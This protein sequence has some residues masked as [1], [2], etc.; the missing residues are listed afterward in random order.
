MTGT[1][2]GEAVAQ[3]PT[4]DQLRAILDAHE[5]WA[6]SNGRDGRPADFHS[7]DLTR[8][9]LRGALLRKADLTGLCAPKADLTGAR[10]YRADLRGANLADARLRG[11]DLS[12]ADL[13]EA[14]LSGA[15]LAGADLSR[16]DL[17]GANV[18]RAVLRDA[19]LADAD[20]SEVHGLLPGQL[21]GAHLAGAK[22]PADILKFE[23]LANVAEASKATQNLFTT[24]ILVCA[25]T[26]LTIASTTD[27]QLLNNAAPPSSR[28]PILG[29]DIPLVRFYM[30]APLLL[31]CLYVYF[32]LGLQRLWEELS[33]LPAVFPDGRALDKKA[34]PW[35]LNVLVRAH[36][37]RLREARSHLAKWQARISTLLAWGLVPATLVLA[38]AR[39]LRAHD[40]LVTGL[41]IALLAAA[42][43][44]GLAF[45]RLAASTLRGSERRSFMWKRAWKDARALGAGV[46]LGT[47]LV[48]VGLS[49]GVIEGVY[50]KSVATPEQARSLIAQHY[51]IDPRRWL[52]QALDSLGLGTSADLTDA[53]LSTKPANWAPNHPE[54]LDA[55]K[56]A[57]LEHRN[58]RHAMAFN[59]FGVNSYLQ[60]SDLRWADFRES[61]LRRADFRAARMRG[62]NFRFA[63]VSGADFRSKTD[64]TAQ[65]LP[66]YADLTEARFKQAKAQGARFKEAILRRANFSEANL[67]GA[68]LEKADLSEAD[69]TKACLESLPPPEGALEPKPT[70]L[71]G[72]RLDRAN[73]TEA[74]LTKA[75]LT[76]A[77][78]RGAKLDGAKLDGTILKGADLTGAT[79]LTFEQL[80]NAITDARTVLPEPARAL[81]RHVPANRR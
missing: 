57:D 31:L 30:V 44:A 25:Y 71:V 42:A 62:I 41:H 24:M 61:D 55:V 33:E 26:W 76:G 80:Q 1:R 34:Y 7:L 64:P 77:S 53:S 67:S 49:M 35:L 29:I 58:L 22:L 20:L 16:A 17:R 46:T 15:N 39:Y 28:L 51:R 75:D 68:D 21:G 12:R 5:A 23:G 47:A 8:A 14:D 79:G 72:A 32:Q 2:P 4:P 69:L 27:A 36:L 56:G 70:R 81:A 11:A 37:P 40:W 52:P 73:L 19:N 48:L 54:L 66:L 45:L 9:E 60:Q 6:R 38:W 59:A 3:P 50:P 78:L 18:R 63:D 10:L 65:T 13:R 74:V 43:G